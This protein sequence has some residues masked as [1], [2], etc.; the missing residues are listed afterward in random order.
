M[1][2]EFKQ[3]TD[4]QFFA[5]LSGDHNPLHTDD[6][7]ARRTFYG[8]KVVHGMELVF[9]ALNRCSFDIGERFVITGISA[10]FDKPA[11]CDEKIVLHI[12]NHKTRKED[13]RYDVL[14]TDD[15]HLSGLAKISFTYEG[16]SEKPTAD[17]RHPGD[18]PHQE[19]RRM[20]FDYTPDDLSFDDILVDRVNCL[21]LGF[22]AYHLRDN[23]VGIRYTMSE[24]QIAELLAI[25]R[26]IGMKVPGKK[27]LFH[28]FELNEKGDGGFCLTSKVDR[29]K[30]PLKMIEL[31]LYGPTLKGSAK[32]SFLP[33][34]R[35][36]AL[37]FKSLGKTN[38]RALVVA[39]TGGLGSAMVEALT[40]SGSEVAFT[41]RK[42][43]WDQAMVLSKKTGAKA[44][45]CSDEP[46]YVME[47]FQPTHLYFMASPRIFDR[48][49]ELFD[50]KK[51]F[52]FTDTYICLLEDYLVCS[53]GCKVFIPSTEALD[54]NP[55]KMYEYIAA[56]GATEAWCKAFEKNNREFQFIIHRM[57]R[58]NTEQT[59][60]NFVKSGNPSEQVM[61]AILAM[62]K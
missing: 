28:S 29:V 32:A 1:K 36:P 59:V 60:S 48:A 13:Q 56:K 8:K 19:V 61:E 42:K 49:G 43:S 26:A 21:Q 24:T 7:Y 40:S 11:F 5:L 4:S 27:A 20:D 6:E 50:N 12:T 18:Q 34:Y 31:K 45:Q 9:A 58:L 30:K 39:G 57:P 51:L 41:Y 3:S 37:D 52:K 16:T 47:E 35:P 23:F 46:N 15:Q 38:Q 22:G 14:I 33:E 54:T 2:K 53:K 55:N 44:Y 17:L 10:V 62:E 25:T